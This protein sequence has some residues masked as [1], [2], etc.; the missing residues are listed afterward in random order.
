MKVKHLVHALMQEDPELNVELTKVLPVT[1]PKTENEEGQAYSMRL[2]FPIIGLAT[3]DDDL[4]LIIE[5]APEMIAFG[6]DIKR[7]D[8][9]P[10]TEEDLKRFGVKA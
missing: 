6:K 7:L 3:K 9:E 2:D 5:A 4:L 1:V 8:G 10:L